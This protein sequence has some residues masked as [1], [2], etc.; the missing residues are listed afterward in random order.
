MSLFRTRGERAVRMYLTRSGGANFSRFVGL[1]YVGGRVYFAETNDGSG[2]G[3]RLYRSTLGASRLDEARGS[4]RYNSVAWTRDRFAVA[5]GLDGPST[6]E[7]TDPIAWERAT[8][9][10]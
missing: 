6:L 8:Q 1:T 3:N 9:L 7:L 10:P 2:T 5:R 4:A